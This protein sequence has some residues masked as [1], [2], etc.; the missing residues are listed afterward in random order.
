MV[1]IKRL[2][3]CYN[4]LYL[5]LAHY[6]IDCYKSLCTRFLIAVGELTQL[7]PKNTISVCTNISFGF[8][9]SSVALLAKNK[10]Y[11]FRFLTVCWLKGIR[12]EVLYKLA[13]YSLSFCNLAIRIHRKLKQIKI[14]FPQTRNQQLHNH[15]CETYLRLLERFLPI[16]AI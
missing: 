16:R 4:V 3:K 15:D 1:Y 10:I 12:Q 5:V 13:G 11:F 8:C 14:T 9:I 2:W 6:K 7:L